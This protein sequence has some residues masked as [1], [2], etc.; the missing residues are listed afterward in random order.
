MVVYLEKEFG[1]D[2]NKE[3]FLIK[4][5]DT[6][7]RRRKRRKGLK[8][9]GCMKFCQMAVNL[10]GQWMIRKTLD[11]DDHNAVTLTFDD[12]DNCYDSNDIEYTEYADE[13][14]DFEIVEGVPD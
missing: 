13:E 8:R 1:N 4:E 2:T 9:E 11:T 6:A 14:D 3:Y 10:L 12:P 5:E 7:A